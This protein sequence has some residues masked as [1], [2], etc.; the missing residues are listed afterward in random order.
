MRTFLTMTA[1]SSETIPALSGLSE[2][3][4]GYDGFIVD[5]WGV[6]HDGVAA[7]PEALDGL[8]R[9]R[10]LGKRVV[11]LSN[12]PRRAQAVAD[13]NAEMGIG[14]EHFDAIATSGEMTWRHLKERRDPWYRALGRRC[15]PVGPKRDHGLREGLDYDFVETVIDAD[16]VLLTGALT[17][18][19]RPEDY[20]PLLDQALTRRLPL[21]CANPDLVVIRGGRREICAGAIAEL[22]RDLGGEVRAH[23]KPGRE[24]YERCFALLGIAAR[25]RI[26]A[27]GDSLA[28]D[29]AG[30]QAA[31]IDGLFVLSGIH[32]QE[33]ALDERGRAPPDRLAALCSRY[34]ARPRAVLPRFCW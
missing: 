9:L 26:A 3:A 7:F 2:L 32:D 21:V 5:L 13:R 24:I 4:N 10:A 25:E 20:R 11:I 16:F 33:L 29:I 22:Y 28:T 17:A 8:G 18:D 27:V 12:A 19:D 31:G 1:I 23:G 30:A 34:A 15:Y 6:L 14:P